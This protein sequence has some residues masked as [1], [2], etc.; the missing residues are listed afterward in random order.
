MDKEKALAL[1]LR[2]KTFEEIGLEMNR[3][4]SNVISALNPPVAIRVIVAD[5]CR[6]ICQ[7]CYIGVGKKEGHIHEIGATKLD[8]YTD[9][10][11]LTL[12]CRP[13][14]QTAHERKT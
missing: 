13:C 10:D 5:R 11:N 8:K 3:T 6:G 4:P 1:R 9:L 2:G 7:T 12:L 14:A